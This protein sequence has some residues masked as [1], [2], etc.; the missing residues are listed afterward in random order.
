M[1]VCLCEVES[2]KRQGY[3]LMRRLTALDR[4]NGCKDVKTSVATETY[5][6]S[7]IWLCTESCIY[8]YIM[9]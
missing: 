3:G 9:L 6:V 2:I 5:V 7:N 8:I 1:Y 4:E